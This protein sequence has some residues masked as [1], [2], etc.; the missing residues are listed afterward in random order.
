M[1]EPPKAELLQEGIL[2]LLH[3]FARDVLVRMK[4]LE[5]EKT[6]PSFMISTFK[7][8]ILRVGLFFSISN[9]FVTKTSLA[10]KWRSFSSSNLA[11]IQ[12]KCWGFVAKPSNHNC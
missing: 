3:L 2:F 5:I 9:F 6:K 4:K 12:P 10:N 7:T 1:V 11:L 8:D